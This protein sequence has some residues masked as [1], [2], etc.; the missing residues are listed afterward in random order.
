MGHAG[1]PQDVWDGQEAA[2]VTE[3]V[4]GQGSEAAMCGHAGEGVR[5]T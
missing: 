5:G 2:D 3:Q 4:L 1:E